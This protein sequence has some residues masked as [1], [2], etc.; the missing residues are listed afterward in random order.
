MVGVM[1]TTIALT[2]VLLVAAPAYAGSANPNLHP[3]D[4]STPGI[5]PTGSDTPNRPRT[6]TNDYGVRYMNGEPALGCKQRT[7]N[8][9]APDGRSGPT[10]VITCRW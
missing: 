6:D 1:Q 7:M 10:N 3:W 4:R 2:F 8:A 9:A 5:T